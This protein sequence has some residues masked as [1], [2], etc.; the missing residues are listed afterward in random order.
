[1]SYCLLRFLQVPDERTAFRGPQHDQIIVLCQTAFWKTTFPLFR[2]L[3]AHLRYSGS[4]AAQTL[5]SLFEKISL[6][7]RNLLVR[8]DLVHSN[9]K[10]YSTPVNLHIAIFG[11]CMPS[12]TTSHNSSPEGLSF[13][14]AERH[15]WHYEV[16]QNVFLT[17]CTQRPSGAMRDVSC[18][19]FFLCTTPRKNGMTGQSCIKLL[20]MSPV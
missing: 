11:S 1:M 9:T 17:K 12:Q 16:H 19:N 7:S 6:S 18:Y 13:C 20:Q 15:L 8:T 10:L 14:G 5:D 2:I 4:S 3:F